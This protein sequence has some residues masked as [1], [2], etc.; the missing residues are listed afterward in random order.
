LFGQPNFN[1]ANLADP[2]AVDGVQ[3]GIVSSLAGN[4]N[5]GLTSVPLIDGIVT[6]TLSGMGAFNPAT[7]ITSARFQYGTGL[8]EPSFPGGPPVGP[9]PF[10]D[11]PIPAPEPASM[12]L[13]GTG[14]LG[15]ARGARRRFKRQSVVS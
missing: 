15:L 4:A 12:V 8:T 1:G 5:S 13:L 3:F 2:D 7:A 9:D 6:F 14:L 10:S 11:D